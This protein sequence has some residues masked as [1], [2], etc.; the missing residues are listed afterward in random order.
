MTDQSIGAARID[1]VVD[2]QQFDSAITAAKRGVADMSVSAQQ[3]Y[4][5]LSR[6]ERSRVDTL[7]RQADTLG[8]TRSQQLAYNAALRTS[9]P[10][11]DEIVQKLARA[12]AAAKRSGKELNAY[13][14]SAAQQ[15]AA[16]RGVPAQITD[17]AVSLQGGQN[18]LTVFLQQGGQLKDMFG[19]IRP[20]A[21]A[22]ASQLLTLINPLTAAA[23]A[24]A[25]LGV[26]WYQVGE[27]QRQ[28]EL[29]LITTGNYAGTSAE[30]IAA[31]ARQM[32]NLGGVTRGKALAALTQVAASGRFTGE[33]FR[34]V[35]ESAAQ[36]EGATGQ[37]IDTTIAKFQ[38]IAK[39]PVE[40]LLKLNEAE[41]FL[42]RAQLDRIVALQDEGKEQEAVSAAVRI[43]HDNLDDVAAKARETLSA[44]TLWW[45]EVK[46]GTS[47]A[48]NELG[49]Y[50]DLTDRLA[51]RYVGTDKGTVAKGAAVFTPVTGQ[52]K[53]AGELLGAVNNWAERY[54]GLAP[55]PTVKMDGIY[56]NGEEAAINSAGERKRLEQRKK[57]Q[58]EWDRLAGQ[59]L[60]KRQKQLAEE[61]QIVALG[62]KLGK[63]QADIDREVAASRKQFAEAEA[64]SGGGSKTNPATSIVARIQQ[65]VALN[66]EQSGSEEKLTVSQRLRVQV[67]EEL[68]RL[69]SKIP[70]ADRKRIRTMLEE[71]K[72]TGDL[73]E[74]KDKQKKT[75]E[76]LTRQQ[77]IF[78]QQAESRRRGNELDLM[79]YGRGQ[80]TVAQLR[81]QMDVQREYEDEL[82]RLGD[83]QVATD[84]EQWDQLAANAARHRDEQLRLEDDYQAR[85][86]AAM[87]DWRNGSRAAF[88][89]YAAD[90]R[91]I[92]GLTQDALTNAFQGAED[93]LVQF[94]MT[95]KISFRE[96]A[97]S[98][99]ADLA[100]IAAKQ[101]VTGLANMFGSF[102]GGGVSSAGNAAV[103][104]GTQQINAGLLANIGRNAKGNVYSSPSLSAYSGDVYNSP[105]LFA[106][107]KGAG[108]FGEAGPEAIMPLKRG[109]DGR[110]GVSSSGSAQGVVVEINNYSGNRVEQR[111]EKQTQPDGS[112]LRR[113]IID[114]AAESLDNGQLGQVGK[115]RYG[116]Q[117][118]V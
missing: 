15:A 85:R 2:T 100:R 18:P 109:P 64:R 115:A 26:A 53:M 52:F 62:K 43:Y 66:K 92:A 57:D 47:E 38:E 45:Q 76:A 98:I 30:Q 44:T 94:A 27:A 40:A 4:Q 63:D 113:M 8:M 72:T 86:L 102:W 106:F 20:A 105:Q 83:R 31:L 16:M 29:A 19:G 36:M 23:A 14:V 116:W 67:L 65:Q 34:L 97:N 42:K 41:H 6:A 59:N 82:K 110:L 73:V 108:V 81:R 46:K 13:G 56:G 95:G 22:L 70:E 60:S 58:Q 87:G 39:D 9:G 10:V 37:S 91:N 49:R 101:A 25:A 61:A 32:D 50:I 28:A 88:D 93:A 78:D 84:Q 1:L 114:I 21:A 69:G 80:D 35:S 99:I 96:L 90:A 7:V 118:S 5:Q 3:Q 75:L 112:V 107:A 12:E 71:L 48:F 24:T 11:L 68:D 74:A 55:K 77:A 51:T 117:E 103:T 17:I 33:Q 89:D 111:E 79:S 54:W 104:N